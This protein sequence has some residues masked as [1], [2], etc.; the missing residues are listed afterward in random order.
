MW[1]NNLFKSHLSN[2]FL[3]V[4]KKTDKRQEVIS[5]NVSVSFPFRYFHPASAYKRMHSDRKK[6]VWFAFCVFSGR[7][8]TWNKSLWP[9]AVFLI[10]FKQQWSFLA[11]RDE[12]SGTQTWCLLVGQPYCEPLSVRAGFI[13]TIRMSTACPAFS[14]TDTFVCWNA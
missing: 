11:R 7:R 1:L 10:S 2:D 9:T 3:V 6:V 5:K 14:L 13:D 4:V 8:L 12:A